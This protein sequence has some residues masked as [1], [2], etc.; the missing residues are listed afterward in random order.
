MNSPRTDRICR[1]VFSFWSHTWDIQA[2]SLDVSD[3]VLER[4][5]GP[6]FYHCLGLDLHLLAGFGVPACPGV[7][8]DGIKRAQ[9]C[10][11]NFKAFDQGHVDG[12]DGCLDGCLGIFSLE[13]GFFGDEIDDVFLV[14]AV[15]SLR[16]VFMRSD[17]WN[18]IAF[19]VVGLYFCGDNAVEL[20][21][22]GPPV[23][24]V[25]VDTM[26]GLDFSGRGHS[27]KNVLQD[28][29]YAATVMVGELH[30]LPVGSGA[31]LDGLP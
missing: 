28:R 27:G 16:L 22:G 23:E 29:V 13:P 15:I 17:T 5:A 9:T 2:L 6:E 18:Y 24:L 1:S 19:L 7:P 4:L 10:H 12:L 26:A 8:M 21:P 14:H 20:V 3:Q 31:D 25:T 30:E 11:L